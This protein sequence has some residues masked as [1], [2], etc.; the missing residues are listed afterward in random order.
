MPVRRVLTGF[1]ALG[2][3][4]LVT[5]AIGFVAL[6]VAARRLGP[7]NLGSATLAINITLYFAIPANFGLTLLG[8][9]DIAREPERSR[10]IVGEILVLRIVLAVAMAALLL[11]V[12]PLVA[13]D[14]RTQDLLPLA[15]LLIPIDAFNGEWVLFGQ[16]RPVGVAFARL[17]G[18]TAYGALV[19]L[20][21][22]GGLHGARQYVGYT[23]LSV[24]ITALLAQSLA[25]RRMGRPRPTVNRAALWRRTAASFPLGIAVIAVQVYVSIGAV[26]L[27]Y[28]NDSA[29]VGQF[30][31]A[32]KL[33]LA[34]IGVV[35]LWSASL[36]PQAA[37]LMAERRDELRAQVSLFTNLSVVMG[38]PLA[39][40]AIVVGPD[41]IRLLFGPA[42]GPAGP[43]F[44]WIMGA[45]A[46]SLLT[47]NVSSVLAAGG[48]E[49]RYAVGRTIGA[50][51]SV[52]VNAAAI[53][54]FGVEGA[55]ATMLIA[56]A[57]VLAYMFLRYLR[58]VGP[59]AVDATRAV[60]AAAA[61][62]IMAGAVLAVGDGVPVLL[63]IALGVAVYAVAGVAVGVLRR[64]EL[65]RLLSA[66]RA[67]PPDG[68]PPA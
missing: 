45:I 64:D 6:A 2:A 16:Q 7:G 59:V 38:L 4:T 67:P 56:E 47:V 9:R 48:D 42:Y 26:M 46:L 32:Q 66:R 36:Y 1:A 23:V 54:L 27:G 5:Q 8:I 21:I 68:V 29:A 60:R 11:G 15:A 34:L 63:R 53:P 61:T 31:V 20:L 12:T 65:R 30:S 19:V 22:T 39:A 50:V 37:K 17:A 49:R 14:A 33:P 35:Q 43:A 3:T 52:L 41:L 62:A 18:Q 55:A 40:G 13:A 24:L 28:L 58:V 51:A 44:A 10:E 25:W 57:L